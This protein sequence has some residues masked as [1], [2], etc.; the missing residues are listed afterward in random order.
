MHG[1]CSTFVYM[2]NFASTDVRVS[3]V[4]MCKINHFLYFTKFG[5]FLCDYFKG[6][7]MKKGEAVA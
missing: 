6:G 7:F 1:Y 3:L 2:H 5:N 4:K